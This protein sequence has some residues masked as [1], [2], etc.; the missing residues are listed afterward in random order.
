M[1]FDILRAAA[2]AGSLLVAA[3]ATTGSGDA[4][5]GQQLS[6]KE[7]VVEDIAGRGVIDDSR[8]SLLFGQDGRLSGSASCNRIVAGYTVNGSKLTIDKAGLTM[9]LCP[10]AI[11]DQERRLMDVLNAVRSYRIDPTGALVLTSATG[12]TVT[13]R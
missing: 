1:K 7:W 12:A 6:S 10:P 2:M 3:C 8:A 5:S 13:A 11:M 4:G 9:M